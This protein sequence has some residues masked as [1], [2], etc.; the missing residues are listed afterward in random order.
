MYLGICLDVQ[1]ASHFADVTDAIL[2]SDNST[3]EMFFGQ[4]TS[5]SK[6]QMVT[7]VVLDVA[8][9]KIVLLG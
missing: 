7:T 5:P 9:R 8:W 4:R 3:L 1:Y 6:W 2:V